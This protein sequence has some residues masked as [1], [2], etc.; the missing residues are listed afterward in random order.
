MRKILVVLA[1][2]HSVFAFA[3]QYELRE[4][5]RQDVIDFEEEPKRFIRQNFS[6]K[7]GKTAVASLSHNYIIN[8]NEHIFTGYLNLQNENE[9]FKLV[10]GN[11]NI[12]FGSGLFFGTRQ[13][14]SQDPF[15]SRPFPMSGKFIAPS[16]SANPVYSL[17]GLAVSVTLAQT[18]DISVFA[19]LRRRYT[20]EDYYENEKVP[21][22]ITSINSRAAPEGLYCEPVFI[23]DAGC[24]VALNTENF[25]S[26]L[27]IYYEDVKDM[28]GDDIVWEYAKGYS[29]EDGIRSAFGT[30]GYLRYT[31][32]YVFVY[33]E[34]GL[35]FTQRYVA[36]SN[37]YDIGGY[38][39]STG[40]RFRNRTAAFS[41]YSLT[42]GSSF[43]A[44]EASENMFPRHECHASASLKVLEF[45]QL[46]GSASYEHKD[47]PG[48]TEAALSTAVKE[49]VFAVVGNKKLEAKG[50][51][52]ISSNDKAAGR[53]RQFREAASLSWMFAKKISL[54]AKGQ[55]THKDEGAVSWSSG[56]GII[57]EAYN[58]FRFGFDTTFYN[59][60]GPAIYATVLP[61][62]NALVST[63]Y[64]GNSCI[65]SV[66]KI[67]IKF[68]DVRFTARYRQFYEGN[69]FGASRFEF[70]GRAVF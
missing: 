39:V 10:A 42:T 33:C 51:F 29:S 30:S 34:A 11:F 24:S 27:F 23:R 8:D 41:L 45:M 61:A 48:K 50:S 67:S 57:G 60:K 14:I 58:S 13:Y 40:F 16:G 1:V 38:A 3:A 19:S 56:G 52:N 69:E 55:W 68:N 4:E 46:G 32:D 64:I 37:N 44:P 25:Y 2:L 63:T 62:E 36:D 15:A 21:S 5:F 66:F 7:P 54:V 47:Y 9:R 49:G 28:A 20:R 6:I 65:A 18:L 31:D 43:Y 53:N 70:M 26:A 59:I 17:C 35:S 22:S 12:N